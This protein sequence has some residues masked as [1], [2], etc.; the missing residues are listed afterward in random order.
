MLLSLQQ[1]EI[2]LTM[3]KSQLVLIAQAMGHSW[4][5]SDSLKISVAL[6]AIF[7]VA[8]KCALHNSFQ[9]ETISH[10]KGKNQTG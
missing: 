5:M 8:S 7:I 1:A 4:S 3:H 6:Q 10:Q 2:H 9:R